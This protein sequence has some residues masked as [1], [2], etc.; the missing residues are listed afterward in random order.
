MAEAT[1]G[2]QTTGLF[3]HHLSKRARSLPSVF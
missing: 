2:N 3:C 1:S